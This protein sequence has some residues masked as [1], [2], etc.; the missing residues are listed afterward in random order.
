MNKSFFLYLFIL[1]FT[2]ISRGNAQS[3]T[4][5]REF[6]GVWLT[7]VNNLDWPSHNSLSV[8]EQKKELIDIL[9]NLQQLHFNA[10]IFQIRPTADAFYQSETEPWS[11]YL[12]G[13]Q[14]NAPE[15]N[16]DP[17]QF[18]IKE[19]HQRGMELHAWMNPFRIA[20]KSSDELSPENIA[21][22]HPEW[23]V[24]YGSKQY[25]NPG[26]PEVRQYLNEIVIEVIENY[27]VDAIHFDDYF[28]PYPIAG[29][30]FPDEK[31]FQ[32]YGKQFESIENWRRDNVD[33]IIE[34][35]HNS[36]KL[37]KP[38]VKFGIS[39][40]GVWKNY[41]DNDQI[42]GSVTSAGNTNYDN[43][44]AD[45]IK[46]QQK[47]WID[48]M[49]PQIY[50]EIGHPA[51]DYITLKNWWSENSFGHHVYIGHAIYKAMDSNKIAWQNPNEIPEQVKIA[52][53]SEAIQGSAFF[54]YYHL[55]QNPLGITNNLQKSLFKA[56]AFLP[57]MPWL[58]NTPP[59]KPRKL[60]T[61]GLF[62]LNKLKWKANQRNDFLAYALYFSIAK[63]TV[64][65]DPE[66]LI[67]FTQE[68]TIDINE[69]V[70][71]FNETTYFWVTAI[72]R[73]HNESSPKGPLTIKFK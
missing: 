19:C 4:P 30:T 69:I 43:L 26:I 62:K 36:I 38:T 15:Q 42:S 48:Y 50:W 40:F 6:R 8:A 53:R 58:D 18:I 47:G 66:H 45:V 16:F 73:H 23:V 34:T 39:P 54:R 33:Q 44:Y 22:R 67:L 5:K 37:N 11:V 64:S 49:I 32:Q 46:W 1:L 10:V 9:D 70:N 55:K 21:R 7:T 28:Y 63:D 60:K 72:D 71:R 51:V 68:N 59:K 13:K 25:L 24:T 17:L 3:Q 27:E 12:T 2:I 56:P 31:E 65:L 52:R 29:K 35:I 20:Q 14:G 41:E 57:T 61:K